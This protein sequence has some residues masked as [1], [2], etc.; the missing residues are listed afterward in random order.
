MAAHVRLV[1]GCRL[2][3]RIVQRA[4]AMTQYSQR[5]PHASS[6]INVEQ[7]VTLGSTPFELADYSECR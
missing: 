4:V 5:L 7:G 1:I 2:E 6:G 3:V